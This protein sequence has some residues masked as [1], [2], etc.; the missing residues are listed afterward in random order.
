MTIDMA[1]GRN[2]LH[3]PSLSISGFAGINDLSVPHLGRVTLFTG[4][5]AV[6]KTTVLDAIRVYA[7]RGDHGV[8]TSILRKREETTET[9]DEDG[10]KIPGPNW[11]ALFYG[12]SISDKTM[13]SIGASSHND[14]ELNIAV[15]DYGTKELDEEF[16]RYLLREGVQFLQVS[17]DGKRRYSPML[18]D[19]FSGGSY[20]G[21]D[22]VALERYR[23][24]RPEGIVTEWLGPGLPSNERLARFWDKV[25]LTD[26]EER[27]VQ[28]LNLIFHGTVERVAMIGSER[29]SRYGHA[30]RAVVRIRGQR[31]PVPLTSLGDGATRLFGIALALANS[32]DGFLLIDEAEN[33]IHHSVH[34][35]LWAMVLRTAHENN[36]QVFATT[37]G[38][39]CIVGYASATVASEGV[40]GTL[41]RIERDGEDLT[42]VE[43]SE[44]NLRTAALQ[45]IEVRGY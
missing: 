28:A 33:G 11:D 5:N 38:W 13:L 41:V 45:R 31:Q 26:K 24:D 44:E 20:R 36:V 25:A 27:I 23:R 39:D 29:G 37:H 34:H 6:G 7:A 1:S 2:G 32:Q 15:V 30:R 16:P 40:C 19:T 12:R 9:E 18:T 3:L 21:R 35:D 4:K 22:R 14:T 43:Y 17:F 8:L 42:A 10:R